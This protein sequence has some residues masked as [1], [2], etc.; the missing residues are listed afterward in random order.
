MFDLPPTLPQ[1]LVPPLATPTSPTRSAARAYAES[2]YEQTIEI[3]AP[4]VASGLATPSDLVLYVR[5]LA[6]LGRLEDASRVCA[7]ALD[8]RR[9]IP[10][11]HYLQAVLVA[12]GGQFAESVL[13]ARR[14]LYLDRSMIV[15]HLALGSALVS[16]GDTEGARR[17]FTVSERL[18]SAMP[19]DEEVPASDGEPAG[20]LLEMTRVQAKLAR[21]ESAA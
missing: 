16:S 7:E 21:G 4:D 6:N 2:D 5:A 15:A 10:E 20:R 9:D 8:H 12:Q 19:P 13:A 1:P 3:V 18:L 11:L 14:A 17:A